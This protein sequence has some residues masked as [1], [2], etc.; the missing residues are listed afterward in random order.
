MRASLQV[1]N[2]S[3]RL[4]RVSKNADAPIPMAMYRIACGYRI[5]LGGEGLYFKKPMPSTCQI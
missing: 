3:Y 2:Y 5:P 4:S 1:G